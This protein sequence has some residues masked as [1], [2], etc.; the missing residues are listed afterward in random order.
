MVAKVAGQTVP[1]ARL[2]SL[3]VDQDLNQPDMCVMTLGNEDHAF[4][5]GIKHGDAVEV[6]VGDG[7]KV[8]FKGEVVGLEPFY[9]AGGESKCVVRAFN[10]M[11][12]LLRGRKSRTFLDQSDQDIAGTIAGDSGLSPECGSS[13]KITHKHVYQHNQTNLEFLRLRAARLGFDVWVD[14]DKLHF[15][16]PKSDVDSGIK[17]TSA[18]PVGSEGTDI[19]LI[20]F[21]PRMSSS[22]VVKKVIVRG[23]DPEKKEEIVGEASVANSQ[24]G[25]KTGE[26]QSTSFGT[27][28]TF[29][30]DHPI[31]SVD[32]AKAIAE[33][34][35]GELS[36]AY[37]T[38]EAWIPGSGDIKAGIVVEITINR[39]KPEDRFNGKYM[40]V[41]AS[42]SYTHA[43][44]G[45]GSGGG[46]GYK[47]QVRVA[48]DA[49][50]SGATVPWPEGEAE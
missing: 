47:T 25:D 46:G 36:M 32:E 34:R 6:T 9:K 8:I 4:S 45:G 29:E 5:N 13:P 26:S 2:L 14:G 3:T 10:K 19:K 44:G 38:G 20:S 31:F 11:H 27:V 17:L 22:A 30:V 18:S 1:G 24:L 16:K 35:L 33:S 42:H 48:R 41:G 7:N 23:W 43:K 49:Q 37:I 40:V 21:A 50:G 28:E 39:D 15:D 12:R